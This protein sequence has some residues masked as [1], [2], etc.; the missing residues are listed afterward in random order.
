[1]KIKISFRIL[2]SIHFF[3]MVS[4]SLLFFN[5]VCAQQFKIAENGDTLNR[6]NANGKKVGKWTIEIPELRGEPGYT[7]EGAYDTSGEK[8]G[9]WRRYSIQGDLIGL[10]NY[11]HGGKAGTQKYYNY[12]G[13]LE[14]EEN[15]RPYNPDAPYDT[16]PIYGEGNGEI[17]S[18]KI[19]KSQ[20]YSIKD[21]VWKYYNTENGSIIKT[22]NWDRNVLLLP[23]EK[24]KEINNNQSKKVDKTPE[25]LKWE[26]KNKENK[27]Y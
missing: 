1:M 19:V 20:P 18:Y 14:R 17:V 11:I 13:M 5:A 10:E 12:L 15:W 25:M 3:F 24:R 21:G 7:E 23:D 8:D 22:E 4:I 9:Y 16:I 2:R 6:T 26:M 27:K